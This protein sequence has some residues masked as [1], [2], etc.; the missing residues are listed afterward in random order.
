MTYGYKKKNKSI[1]QVYYKVIMN[2]FIYS[3]EYLR[4]IFR[5]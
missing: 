3:A 4:D 5:A 1:Q 2:I